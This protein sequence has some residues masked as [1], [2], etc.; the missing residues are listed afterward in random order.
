MF[1]IDL[2]QPLQAAGGIPLQPGAEELLGPLDPLHNRHA[3]IKLTSNLSDT[4]TLATRLLDGLL[5]R[6]RETSGPEFSRMW[7]AFFGLVRKSFSAW[8]VTSLI[9]VHFVRLKTNNTVQ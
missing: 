2:P 1:W 5:N 8:V 6:S 4:R 7:S 9:G 3:N